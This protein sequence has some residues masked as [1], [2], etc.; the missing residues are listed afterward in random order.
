MLGNQKS[1]TS[2]IVSLLGEASKESYTNDIFTWYGDAEQRVLDQ[3]MSFDTFVQLARY[4]FSKTF[5]KDPG[6]T[7][8]LD[9]VQTRFPRAKFVFVIRNPL[10]NIRSILNRLSLPGDLSDLRNEDWEQ[11]RHA[12]P[13]WMPV[14][15]GDSGGYKDGSYIERLAHRC[16]IALEIAASG[17]E[18]WEIIRYEDFLGDKCGVISKTLGVLGFETKS[19]VSEIADKPFQPASTVTLPPLEYFGQQNY[20]LIVQVCGAAMAE[21]GYEVQS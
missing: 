2:A 16:R 8:L 4:E 11:I 12:R 14:V 20:N 17:K 10:T 1:G 9:E 21:F 3:Q 5:I 13:N 18:Q 7:F 19:D 6:L 15:T